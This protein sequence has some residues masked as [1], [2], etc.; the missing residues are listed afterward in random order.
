M[1]RIAASADRRFAGAADTSGV[2]EYGAD[3]PRARLMV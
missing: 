2:A 3:R 1:V